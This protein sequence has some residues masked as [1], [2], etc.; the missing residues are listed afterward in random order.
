[1]VQQK[2]VVLGK[3]KM[4]EF[5]I[6]SNFFPPSSKVSLLI[7]TNEKTS[8]VFQGN[9]H[10]R[11]NSNATQTLG[12]LRS[13]ARFP[14]NLCGQP[15]PARLPPSGPRGPAGRATERPSTAGDA[16]ATARLRGHLAGRLPSR[17]EEPTRCGRRPRSGRDPE[18][19]GRQRRMRFG[20]KPLTASPPRRVSRVA[21]PRGVPGPRGA[22]AAPTPSPDAP[23]LR[24]GDRLAPGPRPLAAHAGRGRRFEGVAWPAG[25]RRLPWCT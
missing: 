4:S 11:Q 20:E 23:V 21:S 10:R 13:G 6:K 25:R 14:R 5:V 15:A 9:C 24:G 19:E 22:S 7:S 8:Q 18:S 12:P 16:E 1:M 2:T 17:L 3:P